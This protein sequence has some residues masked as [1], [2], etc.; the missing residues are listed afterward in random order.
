MLKQHYAAVSLVLL[1]VLTVAVSKLSLSAKANFVFPPANP[2]I[3]IVSPTNSTYNMATLS[4]KVTFDTYKTGYP[5]GPDSDKTRLF[6][7][8][9]DGETQ[10][11]ITI[12]R[13]SVAMNPGYDVFFEGSERLPE[14]AEGQ[15]NLTVRVVFVYDNP[16]EEYIVGGIY[17]ESESTV[18][19]RIDLVPQNVSV[20]K[21]ENI[22]YTPTDVPLL[23]FVDEPASWIGYSLDEQENVTVTGNTTLP[24]L[25]VG[26]HTLM[27]Y[28]NDAAGNPADAKTV[29]FSVVEPFLTVPVVVASG[30]SI[31]AV[32]IGLLVYFKKR[33]RG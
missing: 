29:T 5:G 8:A 22:T 6:T 31:A 12:T 13:F 30:A 17:T 18:C 26:Q 10:K 23:F 33:K 11:N 1:L 21:P 20:L 27:F 14:L 19:F 32:A 25:L 28:A 2:E 16:S 9:L 4:L 15:H 24:E 3:T 7:Y